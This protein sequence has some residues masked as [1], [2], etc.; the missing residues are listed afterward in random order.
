[1]K[2]KPNP[3]PGWFGSAN[4]P[5]TQAEE[6]PH[7][8]GFA[9]RKRNPGEALN[10]V[11]WAKV[12]AILLRGHSFASSSR[13]TGIHERSL[14]K[15]WTQ[16]Y[17]SKP[18]GQTPIRQ[19]AEQE[20]AKSRALRERIAERDTPTPIER[21]EAERI[22]GQ[23]GAASFEEREASKKDALGARTAEA[24][25]VKLARGNVTALAAATVGLLR[26]AKLL[27]AKIGES[28]TRTIDEGKIEP[29]EGVRLLRQTAGFVKDVV[30]TGYRAMEMERLLLGDP[31]GGG[32]V[33]QDAE[34]MSTDD[35]M[36]EL[37]NASKV[38]ASLEAR[39]LRVIQGGRGEPAQQG[40]APT[41]QGVAFDATTS[42]T[43]AAQESTPAS[44]GDTTVEG[45]DAAGADDAAPTAENP[46][47][48]GD[49]SE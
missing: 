29:I 20:K 15:Y 17:P 39:G 23:L 27:A 11:D 30:E 6:T 40:V 16:G 13:M 14:R 4:R 24:T 28:I 25:L 5:E 34:S 31:S 7:P 36:V 22:E 18:W 32:K 3:N 8:H 12:T 49:V 21:E 1:M 45:G 47:P 46:V 37:G 38:F 10:E 19:I 42:R 35:V 26:P 41:E 43:T 9:I 48:E 33:A 44:G 2:P